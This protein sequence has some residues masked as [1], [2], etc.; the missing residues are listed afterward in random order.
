MER[1][2]LPKESINPT[3]RKNTGKSKPEHIA[4]QDSCK[5]CGN[6]I[7]WWGTYQLCNRCL[8]IPLSTFVTRNHIAVSHIA[9]TFEL[10]EY[11]TGEPL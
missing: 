6:K 10:V 7:F 8:E 5:R 4:I 3:F 2:T 9:P 1:K 11:T